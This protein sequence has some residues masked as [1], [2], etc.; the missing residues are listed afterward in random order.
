MT[1]QDQKPPIAF[2]EL[3]GFFRGDTSIN[4]FSAE[5]L[6]DLSF[7]EL[8][9]ILLRKLAREADGQ[10]DPERATQARDLS[11]QV[12]DR[13]SD[14][15]DHEIL[16]LLVDT[17]NSTEINYPRIIAFL[18]ERGLSHL[19]VLSNTPQRVLDQLNMNLDFTF[20]TIPADQV[21][22]TDFNE[23]LRDSTVPEWYHQEQA[24]KKANQP[25]IEL[26]QFLRERWFLIVIILLGL[27]AGVGFTLDIGLNMN[28]VISNTDL[29][30][31]VYGAIALSR[32]VWQTSRAERW[33]KQ[34]RHEVRSEY[35]DSLQSLVTNIEDPDLQQAVAA[36]PEVAKLLA[37]IEKT[38][39]KSNPW[40]AYKKQMGLN[41]DDNK[42]GH[43]DRLIDL[44]NA[45]AHKINNQRAGGETIPG[46]SRY[47][48][49][50]NM[51]QDMIKRQFPDGAPSVAVVIPT[52]QT[53]YEEMSRLLKSIK[54]QH[55][56]VTTAYV[57]YNDDPN[58]TENKRQEFLSFQRLVDEMNATGGNN[59]CRFSLLAQPSRGK[60]EAMGMAFA[61][62]RGKQF[63]RDMQ[64]KHPQVMTKDL[65]HMIANLDLDAIPDET[66]DFILNID[67][68]TEIG[69]PYAVLNSAIFMNKHQNAACTTGDV[70][71]VNRDIN[72]LS[73]MTYQRYWRAFF[74]ERAAQAPQ[75][76]C[77]SGPWVFMRSEAL[78]QILDDWYF[79][80]F[81]EQR[82]TYGD[83]RNLSTRFNEHGWES[84]FIPDSYVLTDCPTDWKTFLKQQLRWNKSFNR[85]NII[86]FAFIHKLSKFVQF[87]V[88]YQQTF[89]FIMLYILANI[90]FKAADIGVDQ[91]LRAGLESLLPYAGAVLAYNE[92]FFGAYGAIKNKDP[93]FLK[94]P[95]Y[96]GYHFGALLWLKLYAIFKMKDTSWGTKGAQFDAPTSQAEQRAAAL[97][98]EEEAMANEIE[99]LI[100]N[101]FDEVGAEM[102]GFSTAASQA[103]E[104]E[105]NNQRDA[106]AGDDNQWTE[107]F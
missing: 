24:E 92:V 48:L 37:Q 11:R 103:H 87:D 6:N 81:F 1:E 83:D 13:A 17:E 98:Q 40:D 2:A 76:T 51:A 23:I 101:M 60:R 53:S 74:V 26:T 106:E 44:I 80:E 25:A 10:D 82:A 50:D 52:Y 63:L 56:P 89:P 68:D 20:K 35:S 42:G 57:V 41:T 75:V 32:A 3:K 70:R 84:L 72:L 91:G 105:E 97:N 93:N 12:L 59:R 73:E 94:S 69:D 107:G 62:G 49:V 90:G 7:N 100:D 65:R 36:D 58:G 77:M 66:H 61:M 96:I 8:Q 29:Y 19:P 78:A 64:A 30:L 31:S 47:E 79:Q 104:P 54:N 43:I 15:I 33:N 28:D 5:M 27:M 21:D 86:L 88:A 46:V 18:K 16:N 102:R 67:S 99:E 55:Y 9:A 39:G 4:D 85:E 14:V 34:A 95:V 22:L 45:H 38:S 71:V